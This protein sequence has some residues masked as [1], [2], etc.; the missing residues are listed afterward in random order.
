MT[1]ARDDGSGT[2]LAAVEHLLEATILKSGDQ[3]ARIEFAVAVPVSR[4]PT[5]IR[6]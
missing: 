1:I 4:C 3:I 6:G 2:A 5:E